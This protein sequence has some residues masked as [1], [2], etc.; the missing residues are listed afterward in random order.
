MTEIEE[1]IIVDP[2]LFQ[3]F[4]DT[5]L[6]HVINQQKIC[7]ERIKFLLDHHANVYSP[8]VFSPNNSMFVSIYD[9]CKSSKEK[10]FLT[11]M[12]DEYYNTHQIPVV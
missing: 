8:M 1:E 10:R 3:I 2:E 6:I 9:Y 4:I 12:F 11:F 7:I 5:A